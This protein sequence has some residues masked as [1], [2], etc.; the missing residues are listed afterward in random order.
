MKI[1]S[2]P[3]VAFR[4]RSVCIEF[5]ATNSA[6]LCDSLPTSQAY[7]AAIFQALWRFPSQFLRLCESRNEL[8]PKLVLVEILNSISLCDFSR[9]TQ[10]RNLLSIVRPKCIVSRISLYIPSNLV[11]IFSHLG[12]KFHPYLTRVSETSPPMTMSLCI[13]A[14][15]FLLPLLFASGYAHH[16]ISTRSPMWHPSS[17]PP[18]PDPYRVTPNRGRSS[19]SSSSIVQSGRDFFTSKGTQGAD[20]LQGVGQRLQ[21]SQLNEQRAYDVAHPL[22]DQA[23]AQYVHWAK[24]AAK[25]KEPYFDP[26]KSPRKLAVIEETSHIAKANIG[27]VNAYLR[28]MHMTVKA[29]G[30]D[31]QSVGLV[32][33]DMQQRMKKH[34]RPLP[35]S[36]PGANA[37]LNRVQGRHRYEDKTRVQTREKEEKAARSLERARKRRKQANRS[38]PSLSTGTRTKQQHS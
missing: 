14:C 22:H 4:V 25:A 19:A 10:A 7:K 1:E 24:E 29:W 35:N 33:K 13:T 30:E 11:A 26:P 17:Q 28:K 18:P 31:V 12:M 37:M 27:N 2:A 3:E 32:N 34:F 23:Q 20:I 8:A 21:A 16:D 6:T 36:L 38:I 9:S 5:F 15:L